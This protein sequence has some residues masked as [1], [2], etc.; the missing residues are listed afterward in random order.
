MN[1][2]ARGLDFQQ[3]LAFFKSYINTDRSTFSTPLEG[4]RVA[5]VNRLALLSVIVCLVLALA[6][7][8]Q[9]LYPQNVFISTGLI[10]FL[11]IPF[12]NSRG[13]YQVAK[14]FYLTTCIVVLVLTSLTAYMGG[15]FN[16]VE[17]VMVGF[18]A[19]SIF[20]YNG[21]VKNLLCIFLFILLLGLKTAKEYFS[22]GVFGMDYYLTLQNVSILC[23]LIIVFSSTFSQSLLKAFDAIYKQEKILYSLIDNVPLFMSM[24]D[25]EGRY[26]IVNKKYV[27][28]FGIPRE[29]FIGTKVED[30]LPP[31]IVETQ[32]PMMRRALAGESP[33]FLEE[34]LMPDGS[35]MY[36][37]GKYL[38][39]ISKNGAIRY[40]TVYVSDVTKLEQAKVELKKANRT[41]D[42][43]FSII[44]HDILSPLN[45]FQSI[46]NISR[47]ESITKEQ[48]FHYQESVNSQLIVLRETISELLDWA[49]IQLDGINAI[50]KYIDINA[51]IQENLRLYQ[52]M[53]DR[54]NIDFIIDSSSE[55]TA[56]MDENHFKIVIRNLV[57]NA[58]KYTSEEGVVNI[59]VASERDFIILKIED[60]GAG[61]EDSLIQSILKKEIQNSEPGTEDEMG[62]GLGLSLSLSLL[63]KNNCEFILKS[64]MEVGTSFEIKIPKQQDKK[65]NLS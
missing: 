58:L 39:V 55:L 8:I 53:V 25:S 49:R 10:S 22:A 46:L 24:F 38:P 3:I 60:T 42:H 15:R 6:T 31:N 36:A 9:G 7:T 62:T 44:A 48:F 11:L 56:W 13:F 4:H 26:I 63:E 27:E 47:D 64:E 17:N 18:I 23:F 54:K 41:K 51:L 29:D 43:L 52:P 57:H 59:A 2:S 33:E 30:I 65:S 20:L 35:T 1:R 5:L 14:N 32:M 12:L 16:D 21:K 45:L 40:A 28:A 61:M 19:I 34:T 37:N 50:P